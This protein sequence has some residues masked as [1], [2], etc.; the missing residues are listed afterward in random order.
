MVCFVEKI[1]HLNYSRE[2]IIFIK[3]LIMKKVFSTAMF[4]MASFFLN[5]LLAQISK[6]DIQIIQGAWGKQKRELV[7]AALAL[8]KTDSAK[9]W[10]EYD[11]YEERRKKIGAERIKIIDD[12]VNSY[13][14]M[15]NEKA[16]AIVNRIFQNDRQNSDLLQQY[17]VIMKKALNPI[18]AAKF[19]HVETFLQ[20][21]IKTQLQGN[22]PYLGDL[23]VQASK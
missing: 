7:S 18:E 15:T 21:Y 14:K 5:Q 20:S 6:D 13:E 11:K 1:D 12:Y 23:H 22:L 8:S 9:F 3:K 4:F 17:Y 2:R 16:D 19:L 10:P